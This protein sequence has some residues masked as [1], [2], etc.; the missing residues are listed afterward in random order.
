MSGRTHLPEIAA[1]HDQF[2]TR[3]ARTHP[4][5]DLDR[6]VRRG[7]VDKQ[8]FERDIALFEL[9]D[10]RRRDRLDIRLLVE[11][12]ADDGNVGHGIAGRCGSGLVNDHGCAA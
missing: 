1:V 5:D 11:A 2:D 9:R 3:I 6:A 7:I 8:V 12:R 10:H 4:A